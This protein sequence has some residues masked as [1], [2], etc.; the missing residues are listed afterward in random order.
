MGVSSF[1]GAVHAGS[2]GALSRADHAAAGSAGG[3]RR[4]W[5]PAAG[6]SAA[7]RRRAAAFFSSS[8]ARV[9]SAC[10]VLPSVSRAGVE[11]H[12][13]DLEA[14]AGPRGAEAREGREQGPQVCLAESAER[15][16][17]SCSWLARSGRG[18]CPP[19][20]LCYGVIHTA[21]RVRVKSVR[22]EFV[23][24]GDTNPRGG[25]QAGVADEDAVCGRLGRG[26]RQAEVRVL[27]AARG[28]GRTSRRWRAGRASRAGRR[29]RLER[30]D[31]AARA[32]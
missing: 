16:W 10:A 23:S 22:N 1:R 7:R 11:R 26:L 21:R 32:S 2:R 12:L 14:V 25:G 15:G 31:R 13:A 9:S 27:A 29:T 24:H 17:L 28:G 5:R 8:A 4:P 3:G 18:R 30:T 20:S 6:G 19:V